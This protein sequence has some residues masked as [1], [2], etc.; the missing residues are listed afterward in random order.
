MASF[1]IFKI[2]KRNC[3]Y[4]LQLGVLNQKHLISD[5]EL[6]LFWEEP[7]NSFSLPCGDGKSDVGLRSWQEIAVNVVTW[8]A[9]IGNISV[10][11]HRFL[12]LLVFGRIGFGHIGNAK[13]NARLKDKDWIVWWLLATVDA[14]NLFLH[15]HVGEE[16]EAWL[17]AKIFGFAGD[18]TVMIRYLWFDQWLAANRP[19]I[20]T[21]AWVTSREDGLRQ[22]AKSRAAF[23]T[24]SRCL[25]PAW[26]TSVYTEI[27]EEC[28]ANNW[29]IRFRNG[30]RIGQNILLSLSDSL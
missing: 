4:P 17:P 14:R 26:A 6:D 24:R 7:H 3:D 10:W 16:T 28:P 23:Y 18:R 8:S 15:L 13:P 2:L 12:T 20:M 21:N 29:Q 11:Q 22:V 5:T 27:R 9:L 30:D 19:M 25:W 1:K